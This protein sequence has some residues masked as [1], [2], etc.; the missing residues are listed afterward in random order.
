MTTSLGDIVLE[1]DPAKAPVTVRNFLAYADKGDYNGTIFHRVHPGFVIQGG[2]RTPDL[3]ELPSG[4]PIRNE[5]LNGLKNVR[6][7]IA[8]ARET[9][10]DSAT[11][12]FYINLTDNPRLDLPRDTTGKAGYAVFGR[13]IAGM[14]TVDRIRGVEVRHIP[15]KDLQNVPIKPVVIER[16]V[17]ITAE[18]AAAAAAGG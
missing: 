1:L 5:W 9:A 8:M 14:D 7:T 16:V 4:R 11:R 10:P 3:T 12:E 13:I 15:E 18:A 17:R 6:G 2:G